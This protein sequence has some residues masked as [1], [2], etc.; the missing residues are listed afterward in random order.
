MDNVEQCHL[1]LILARGKLIYVGPPADALP[2]FG[3]RRIERHLR[4]D[5]EKEPEEWERQFVTSSQYGDYVA[6]RLAAGTRTGSEKPEE[7]ASQLIAGD[8]VP[9]P[10]ETSAARSESAR[11][12]QRGRRTGSSI[13]QTRFGTV[14]ST[15]GV[16]VA[17][18]PA[19]CCPIH[20]V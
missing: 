12:G 6:S 20:A 5:P 1:I 15:Q 3:V 16:D 14:A 19:S 2:Y 9:P 11:P 13:H 17:A 18:T 10:L 4:Q 7:I 8:V